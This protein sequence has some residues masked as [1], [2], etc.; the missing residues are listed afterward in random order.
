MARDQL[1]LESASGTAQQ[2]IAGRDR[3]ILEQQTELH[4]KIYQ[5]DAL[6]TEL[7]T[8]SGA[9]IATRDAIISGLQTEMQVRSPNAMVG[10]R[11]TAE[12][13]QT[14]AE[15][16]AQIEQLRTR[17][18]EQARQA[19]ELVETLQV[20]AAQHT[21]TVQA[22]RRDRPWPR[23]NGEAARVGAAAAEQLAPT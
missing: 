17:A 9:E 1:I 23:L 5:R 15:G 10:C 8:R 6:L 22:L 16:K 4:T 21:Q 18:D 12:C 2:K 11:A 3:L 14:I 20:E 19:D 7:Q 13:R